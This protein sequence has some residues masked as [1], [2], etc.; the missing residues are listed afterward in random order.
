M[1]TQRHLVV[2]RHSHVSQ[3]M[4]NGSHQESADSRT[5]VGKEV[6]ANVIILTYESPK[7]SK[8][9]FRALLRLPDVDHTVE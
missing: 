9:E 1:D 7:S 4:M 8:S 3:K 6:V 5:L 2:T